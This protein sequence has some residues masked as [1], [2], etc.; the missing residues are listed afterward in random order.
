MRCQEL[1]MIIGGET[2]VTVLNKDQSKFSV[3]SDSDK[4]AVSKYVGGLETR[5][6]IVEN[7]SQGYS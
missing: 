7:S 6:G 3:M 1:R 4:T 2:L 5:L